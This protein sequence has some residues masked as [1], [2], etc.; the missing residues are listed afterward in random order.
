MIE[1]SAPRQRESAT[2]WIVLLVVLLTGMAAPI[3][4]Y[5][6][7]PLMPFLMS[8]FHLSGG[9]AGFLMS[10]FAVVGIVLSIPAGFIIHKLGYR[11]TGFLALGWVAVGA[12]LGALTTGSIALL[13]TRLMEGIGLNLLAVV[14]P[15][16]IALYFG[17]KRRAIALGVWNAWYPLGSTITFLTAPLLAS[18]WGWRSVWWFGCFYTLAVGVLYFC[19]IKPRSTGEVQN[20]G[21]ASDSDPIEPGAKSAFLNREVW[22]MSIMFLCFAFMYVAYL[23]WTPMF[24]H[25]M[26]GLSLAHAAF[27]MSVLSLLGIASSPC[28][29]WLLGRMRSPRSMCILVIALFSALAVLTCFLDSKYVLPL[30]IAMGFIGGFIPSASLTPWGQMDDIL[31]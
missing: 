28:S 23:T 19:W 10:V 2:P 24:L 14:S 30:V 20:Y 27:M 5:K 8:E 11:L 22:I 16:I 21:I 12:G 4:Y 6:V 13:S 7:P 17:G 1:P 15:T 29:G 25:R 3:N 26:R 9:L 31:S 18:L